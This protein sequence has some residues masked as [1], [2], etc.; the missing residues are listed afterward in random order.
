MTILRTF[1]ET[2]CPACNGAKD[3][4]TAFCKRCYRELPIGM[5]RGLWK[6]Y[7]IGFEKSFEQAFWFLANRPAQEQK[8][9]FS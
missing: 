2:I 6:R 7:G 3:P 5:Q 1:V 4:H 9:L 8:D